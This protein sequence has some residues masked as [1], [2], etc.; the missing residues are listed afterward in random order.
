MI[1]LD[2]DHL[3][4]LEHGQS[5]EAERLRARLKGLDDAEVAVTIVSF[6]EQTRGWLAYL[7][8]AR[9]SGPERRVFLRCSAPYRPLAR[10]SCVSGIVRLALH[11]AGI[12][13][14]PSRGANLLRHSAATALL[15][16]GATPDAI[17][18]LLRHRCL[19]T[20]LH[21]PSAS[22]RIGPASPDRR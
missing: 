10:S 1:V 16:D 18:A 2:T 19:D 11:R 3:T 5:V 4:F 20:T 7:E 9:P 14:P 17:S 8:R 12:A 6:E 15:R 21:S 13:S 22:C